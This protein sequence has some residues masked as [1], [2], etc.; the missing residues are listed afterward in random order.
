M[1]IFINDVNREFYT[2]KVQK[3]SSSFVA[4]NWFGEATSSVYVLE[5]SFSLAIYSIFFLSA[6]HKTSFAGC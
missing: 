6:L 4:M 1:E 2:V 5:F 3:Y